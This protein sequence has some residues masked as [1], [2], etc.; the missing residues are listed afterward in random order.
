MHA[1]WIIDEPESGH[2]DLLYSLHEN[3]KQSN[4]KEEEA[5]SRQSDNTDEGKDEELEELPEK[6][7]DLRETYFDSDRALLHELEKRGFGDLRVVLVDGY[8]RLIT[9][10]NQHCWFT[11]YYVLD[12]QSKCGN[13]G[14]CSGTCKVHLSNGCSREPSIS[15]W[16]YPRCDKHPRAGVPCFLRRS[17]VPDVVIQ[18]SWGNG[19]N[20]EKHTIEDMLSKGLEREGGQLSMDL[21]RLGYLIK[22][23]FQDKRTTAGQVVKD[24]IGLD[25][26]R[27]PHGT[28]VKQALDP[29][30]PSAEYWRY[31]PGD[32]EVLISIGYVD[33][34]IPP[35]LSSHH[36][37]CKSSY[38]EKYTMKASEIYENLSEFH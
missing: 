29:N 30:D 21:P 35:T 28:T 34:G 38:G 11:Q 2:H 19:F 32:A 1:S 9:P 7:A 8:E 24:V 4:M 16:G 13:W 36:D 23:R 37:T 6:L 12:F 5:T 26:Y 15:Y 27:L 3:P 18:F 31:E 17:P 33:L 14:L 22:I 20:Y 10:S 25:I